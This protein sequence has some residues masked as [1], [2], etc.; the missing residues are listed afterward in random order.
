M[1]KREQRQKQNTGGGQISTGNLRASDSQVTR[2]SL[3]VVFPLALRPLYHKQGDTHG[4][5]DLY[6]FSETR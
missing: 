6:G 2:K 5:P 3:P 4:S 1:K